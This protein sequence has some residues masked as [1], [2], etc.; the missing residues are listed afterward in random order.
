[1]I[2]SDISI[3]WLSSPRLITIASPSVSIVMQDLYDTLRNAETTNMDKPIIVSGSGKEP[4]G[5]GVYVGLTVSLLN[6][7]LAFE[8]RPGPSFIQCTANGGNLVAFDSS[9]N[10]MSPIYTTSYTQIILAASSSATLQEL[11]TVQF[12]G[13]ANEVL[14]KLIP[15]LFAK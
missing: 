12:S 8:N 5:N 11:T 6:A 3:N 13:I 4:L 9:S 15:F 14:K 7:Q 10:S 1:M 2:R